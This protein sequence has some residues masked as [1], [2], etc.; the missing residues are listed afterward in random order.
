MAAI[1]RRTDR[2]TIKYKKD[3]KKKMKAKVHRINY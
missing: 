1:E 3:N 2:I